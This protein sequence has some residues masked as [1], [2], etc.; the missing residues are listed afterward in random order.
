MQDSHPPEQQAGCI[1]CRI[2]RAEV[3]AQVI[4][5]TPDAVAF[6]DLNPQGP[7]HAL[8]I[9][10]RH[11]PALHEADDAALLGHLLLTARQV[12]EQEGLGQSGYRVV[13][14]NG[15]DGG[16]TVGHLHLHVLGGRRFGWP[17]G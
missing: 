1:F 17:P 13:L 2:A 14:N 4:Y 16:Q 10:R 15:P 11:V 9:P 12:A 5:E 8:V 6:R 7:I 3:P